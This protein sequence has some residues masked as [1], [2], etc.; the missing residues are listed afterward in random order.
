MAQLSNADFIRREAEMMGIVLSDRDI[1]VINE[2]WLNTPGCKIRDLLAGIRNVQE[3][4]RAAHLSLLAESL[5][6]LG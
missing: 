3:P 5:G 4:E 1:E 2:K 6:L